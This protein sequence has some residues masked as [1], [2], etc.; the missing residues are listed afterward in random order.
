MN[1]LY[2]DFRLAMSKR[3]EISILTVL[4]IVGVVCAKLNFILV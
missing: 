2:I 3:A 1:Q 4:D